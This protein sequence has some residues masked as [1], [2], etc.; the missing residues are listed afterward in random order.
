MSGELQAG[1]VLLQRAFPSSCLGAGKMAGNVHMVR[2]LQNDAYMSSQSRG[3]G[4][5]R[6][7]TFQLDIVCRACNG[8]HAWDQKELWL[9]SDP[10]VAGRQPPM[11]HRSQ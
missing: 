9:T 3:C 4:A 1:T 8:L 7:K 5:L 10:H 11:A 2:L 6:L